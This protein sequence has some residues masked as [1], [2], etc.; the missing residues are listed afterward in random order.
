M[1]TLRLG[2]ALVEVRLNA[3]EPSGLAAFVR[4]ITEPTPAQPNAHRLTITASDQPRLVLDHEQRTMTLTLR[5]DTT[6]GTRS[7][8]EI[9]I[10]QALTRGLALTEATASHP[11]IPDTVLLHGSALTMAPQ[12]WAVAVLDGGLG[13]GKT[14]L[15]MGLAKRHGQLL[16]DEFAFASITDHDVTV[17]A[18][19]RLP[20]HIRTDMAPQLLPRPTAPTLLYGHDVNGI[21]STATEAAPLRL[22]LIPDQELRAGETKSVTADAARELL[23]CAVTDHLRKL[24]DPC[25]DHVSIFKSPTQIVTIDGAPLCERTGLP[26]RRS[27]HVLHTLAA[28]PT[29]RVGIGEPADLPLS[30][31]A[32]SRRIA[33]AGA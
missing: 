15:A 3:P 31:A 4:R 2:D 5:L 12:G 24:A 17:F 19:P 23:R 30:V 33:G 6:E 9:G 8:V 16:V 7:T 10:L 25:L 1:R 27:E 32:A 20:W 28:I 29:F 18:A 11:R 26:L 14:S 13:Q 21:A 22:I